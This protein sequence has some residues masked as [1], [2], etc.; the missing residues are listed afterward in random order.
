MYQYTTG[1]EFP[2]T[3]TDI[4]CGSRKRNFSS[5]EIGE[6]DGSGAAGTTGTSAAMATELHNINAARYLCI[7]SFPAPDPSADDFTQWKRPNGRDVPL[8][9]A[10]F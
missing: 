9:I 4:F 7:G 6:I 1:F 5:Q 10:I 2:G 3:S 8:G